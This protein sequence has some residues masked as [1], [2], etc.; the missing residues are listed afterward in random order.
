MNLKELSNLSKPWHK[1]PK[2]QYFIGNILFPCP[3]A[4]SAVENIANILEI[5]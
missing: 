4:Q 2:G 1:R 3:L 5:S